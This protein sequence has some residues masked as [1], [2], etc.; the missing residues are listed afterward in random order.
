M[1]ERSWPAVASKLFTT[2]GNATGNITVVSAS[3]LKVGQTVIITA[4][5]LPNLELKIKRVYSG[6]AL[7]VGDKDKG[8]E[9]RRDISAYTTALGAAITANMQERSRVP[10]Q[11]IERAVYEEEPTVAI[12]VIQ[13][14]KYGVPVGGGGGA[15]SDVNVHDGGGTSITSTTV[16]P[17]QG[18]DV[19]ILN[20]PLSVSLDLDLDAILPQFNAVPA[21]SITGS[22]PG[23]AVTL[24]TAT[25]DRNMFTLKNTLNRAV[26]LTL[27]GT[28]WL[29]LDN[30]MGASFDFA[31]NGK[32]L[33][34]GDVVGAYYV[35]VQPQLGSLALSL[36]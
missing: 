33:A 15:S 35:S 27:N 18:L 5:T 25:A 36:I 23:T 14:D 22:T 17:K 20:T 12:R 9:H 21:A 16:G 7:A 10:L 4:A 29:E 30:N 11:E 28:T 31:S 2:D 8:I 13:V 1:F 19:N 24:L 26:R 34:V 6:T 32:K 3:G